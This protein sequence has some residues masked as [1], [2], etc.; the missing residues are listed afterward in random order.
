MFISLK[1][2]Y[3][4]CWS[5]GEGLMFEA[6]AMPRLEKLRVPFDASSGLDF[7]IQHL[8]S[9]RHLSVEI[10]CI[11]ATV[12]EVEALEDALRNTADLLPNCPTL[13]IR[14][15]DDEHVVE[16]KQGKAEGEIQTSG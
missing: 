7:G 16:E 11:G 5:N 14:T 8:S 6:G 10:I 3:F 1:E 9:L 12:R 15:W 4:T 13:E 2:F